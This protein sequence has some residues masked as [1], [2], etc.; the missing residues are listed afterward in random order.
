VQIISVLAVLGLI[1]TGYLVLHYF[2]LPVQCVVASGCHAVLDSAYA[3]VFGMPLAFI[4]LAVYVWLF[5]VSLWNL[6]RVEWRI[7]ANRW[8]WWVSTLGSLVSLYLLWVQAFAIKDFCP[9]CLI[10]A[11]L[12]IGI[13]AVSTFNLSRFHDKVWQRPELI[14]VAFWTTVIALLVAAEAFGLKIQIDH[15]SKRTHME[16]NVVVATQPDG[17]PIY[18]SD[19]DNTLGLRGTE[20]KKK[21]YSFREMALLN[22]LVEREAAQQGVSVNAYV[23]NVVGQQPLVTEAEIDAFIAQNKVKD[24]GNGFNLREAVSRHLIGLK[25]QQM[26]QS[27]LESLKKKYQFSLPT[28]PSIPTINASGHPFLGPQKAPI[29]IVVF[30]DYQ[31]AFC[32]RAHDQLEKLAQ[33]FPGDIRWVHIHY[34]LAAHPQAYA[35]AVAGVCADQ[36]GKFWEYSS[37]LYANM[38]RLTPENLRL[39]AHKLGLNDARFSA[40]LDGKEA[41]EAVDNDIK[42]GK[43]IGIVGTPAIILNG[44]YTEQ[45]PNEMQIRMLLGQRQQSK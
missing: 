14:G 18:M 12:M 44:Q 36:Q 21:L 43:S 1:D 32:A 26:F 13:W 31:C 29:Q 25:Q 39:F 42:L 15:T 6:I 7:P 33:A 5:L 28:L 17:N 40:C 19:V 4:G 3:H 41:R 37:E 45:L 34:P 24:P 30:S 22:M 9:F 10:S 16:E 11:A 8:I 38:T 2:G 27:H 23:Q 35:A 20:I